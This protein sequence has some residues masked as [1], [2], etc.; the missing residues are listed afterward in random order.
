M[1]ITLLGALL[2]PLGVFLFFQGRKKL[3]YLTAF[4]A[5]F[6]ASAVVNIEAVTLGVQPA[7]YAG[8][9]YIT[10]FFFDVTVASDSYHLSRS[11][12]RS[13]LP[14]WFFATVAFLSIFAIP[15]TDQVLVRLPSNEYELLEFRMQNLTQFAYLLFMTTFVSCVSFENLDGM[16][17]T[18]IV[19][20]LVAAA[21]FTC[22]WGWVEAGSIL[23]GYSYPAFLFNNSVSFAQQFGTSF[24]GFNIPRISSVTPEPS[25]FARFLLA[26][27]FIVLY[28]YYHKNLYFKPARA[29]GLLVLFTTTIFAATS[30]TGYAGLIIGGI[31]IYIGI[32]SEDA[33]GWLHPVAL[34]RAFSVLA[35][36]IGL[37]LL[38]AIVVIFTANQ[39]LG[40]SLTEMG[41]LLELLVLNKLETGSGQE[42]LGAA[43]RA[44][45]LVA[46][47][48]VLGVGWG[49]NRTFDLVTNVFATTGILGGGLFFYAHYRIGRQ[50]ADLGRT[51]YTRLGWKEGLKLRSLVLGF[52]VLMATK[53]ISEPDIVYLDQWIFIGLIV[54]LWARLRKESV[55]LQTPANHFE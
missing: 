29:L 42:R 25:M 15:L 7:Y 36:G 40:L 27:T 44:L 49:S 38:M 53:M 43:V 12:L 18:R 4:F 19:R 3:L 34:G 35:A 14:F 17:V 32:Q 21:T 41:N 5:P 24:G 48:P 52:S 31:L 30:S 9:L 51:V 11:R 55:A 39:V 8:M 20:I 2:I 45:E 33:R 47:Q 37:L 26:P 6:T 54:A 23:F 13:V 50:A 10:R 46:E 16:D 22:L 28:D 1:S